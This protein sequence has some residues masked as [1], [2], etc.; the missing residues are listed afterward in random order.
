[1]LAAFGRPADGCAKVRLARRI[2]VDPPLSAQPRESSIDPSSVSDSCSSCTSCQRLAAQLSDARAQLA[3]LEE[4]HT[5]LQ[6]ELEEAMGVIELQKGDIERYRAAYE[7]V[8]PNSPERV[9]AGQLQLA[10]ARVL[11]SLADVPAAADLAANQ[12][13][14]QPQQE[15]KKDGEARDNGTGKKNR[16]PHGR[17]KLDLTGLPVEEQV[18]DPDEVVGAGGEGYVVVGEEVS[19]RVAYRPGS[20]VRLRIVRRKWA[21][22]SEVV[23]EEDTSSPTQDASPI[24]V[25]PVPSSVWP[26]YMADPSAIAEH[27]IAKYGDAL[28]LHR[29]E[30]ISA[31]NGFRVPR[32]TQC[33]WLRGAYDVLYRIVDAMHAESLARAFCIA[34]DATGVRVRAAGACEPWHVFVFIADHDHVVFRY[35]EEHTSDTIQGMLGGFDGYLLGDATPIYNILHRRGAIEVVCWFHLRRYFWRALPTDPDRALEAMALVGRLFKIERECKGLSLSEHTEARRREAKPVL[36]LLDA[37]VQRHRDRVDPRGPLDKAIGYYLNQREGLHRFLE[38][39]RLPLAN[40]GSEQQ[41]RNVK[42]GQHNWLYFMGETG[43]KW[44]T[45]SRSLIASCALHWGAL[46]N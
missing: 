39:G 15:K 10:F 13:A 28:P 20:Y 7:Q 33:G 17:Q 6:A 24:V 46:E 8:R 38:D 22:T 3:A 16:H 21:R 41:L 14:E 2:S 35:A 5:V 29:Q 9:P 32:S 31:R 27:V 40:N 4:D 45:T 19:D 23:T 12:D 25:A 44:Y 34:T 42:L 11:E 18:I 1:M 36:D 43:L 26:G 37:W 30:V